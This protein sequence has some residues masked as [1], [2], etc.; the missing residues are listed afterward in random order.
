MLVVRFSLVWKLHSAFQKVSRLDAGD[1]EITALA[2]DVDAMT[3]AVGTVQS[4]AVVFRFFLA[5]RERGLLLPPL[6]YV[7]SGPLIWRTRRRLPRARQIKSFFSLCLPSKIEKDTYLACFWPAVRR[8]GQAVRCAVRASDARQGAPVR[9]ADRRCALQARRV[10]VL[11]GGISR[12]SPRVLETTPRERTLLSSARH[13]GAKTIL[14]AD[15]RIV[16]AWSATD[17]SARTHREL[18]RQFL[19][20]SRCLKPMGMV[21]VNAYIETFPVPY[22]NSEATLSQHF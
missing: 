19:F 2:F 17:G 20:D 6:E 9:P 22:K 10:S 21:P 3:L 14:S 1:G 16:K 13:G 15:A 12:N 7:A 5:T 18:L 4:G 8:V 11:E